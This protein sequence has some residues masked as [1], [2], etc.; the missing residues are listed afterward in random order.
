MVNSPVLA[1]LEFYNDPSQET[2]NKLQRSLDI[3]YHNG[4]ILKT[5]VDSLLSKAKEHLDDV[6][7][8]SRD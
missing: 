7:N 4:V 6:R 8:E 2:L 3:A 1:Q 5:D